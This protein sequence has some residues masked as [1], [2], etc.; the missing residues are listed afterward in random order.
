MTRDAPTVIVSPHLDDGVLSASAQLVRP[1]ARLLTVFSGAPPADLPLT[2]WGEATAAS[3]MAARHRERL[4]ED[5]A[6]VALLGCEPRYLD[7]PE[8]EFRS[9]PADLDD[10]AGRLAPELDAVAEVWVP[11]AI[12]GHPDHRLARDATLRALDEAGGDP[13]VHL[14]ADLPYALQPGDWPGWVTG[15][16]DDGCAGT[17]MTEALQQ[18][19]LDPSTLGSLVIRLTGDLR[20]RKERAVSCY[21]TQLAAVDLSSEQPRRW[22][23]MLATEVAWRPRW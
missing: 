23:Q 12:G 13:A 1:G 21:R 8:D 11:S 22:E 7:E 4:E 5:R 14:Y 2:P 16:A 9:G 15:V 17:W 6:A 3:S 19:G 10:L 18:V 20:D